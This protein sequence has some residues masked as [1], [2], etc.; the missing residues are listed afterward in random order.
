MTD[1]NA[2]MSAAL[3]DSCC[4]SQQQLSASSA[5][6]HVSGVIGETEITQPGAKIRGASLIGMLAP[7]SNA[8]HALAGGGRDVRIKQM[9]L[10]E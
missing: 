7:V 3:P 4:Q 10:R 8:T 9:R 1:P 5:P 2:L 6:N